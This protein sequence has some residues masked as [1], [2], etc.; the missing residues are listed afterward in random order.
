MNI[1]HGRDLQLRLLEV[2]GLPAS[3]AMG[4]SIYM[5]MDGVATVSVA[6]ALTSEALAVL[7][8]SYASGLAQAL[9]DDEAAGLVGDVA[10]GERDQTQSLG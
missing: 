2:L 4:V 3:H 9:E 8:E 7:G 6:Y 10:I 1:I 5:P